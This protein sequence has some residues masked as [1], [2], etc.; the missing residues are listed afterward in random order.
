MSIT[1]EYIVQGTAKW[2]NHERTLVDCEV[3]FH[4]FDGVLAFTAIESE[5]LEPHV[6]QVWDLV[7]NQGVA[8]DIEL[9]N[10]TQNRLEAVAEIQAIDPTYQ[11]TVVDYG[12][13]GFLSLNEL[14]QI[15]N[16]KQAASE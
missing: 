11:H 2:K 8:G 6:E 13:E 12:Q 9:F 4:Q 3:K 7:V 1:V 10:D 14:M 16:E 15:R 5:P